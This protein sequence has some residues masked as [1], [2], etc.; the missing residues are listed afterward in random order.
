MIQSTAL[1]TT[2]VKYS[3]YYYEPATDRSAEKPLNLP[4]GAAIVGVFPD[5]CMFSA[6]N[7][8]GE[9]FTFRNESQAKATRL[10]PGTWTVYPLK[11]GGVAVFLK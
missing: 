5:D 3:S 9:S 7:E 6:R 2:P 10:G 8:S 4:A 1:A 11:C